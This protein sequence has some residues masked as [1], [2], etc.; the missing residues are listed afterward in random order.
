[1]LLSFNKYHLFL[2]SSSFFNFTFVLVLSRLIIIII[3]FRR[4]LLDEASP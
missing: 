1:M 2:K 4:S 3:A